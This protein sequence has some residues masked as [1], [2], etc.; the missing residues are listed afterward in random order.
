MN[1]ENEE[2]Y[3]QFEPK[4]EL[5]NLNANGIEPECI[6]GNC[7]VSCSGKYLEPCTVSCGGLYSS[8]SQNQVYS[9]LCNWFSGSTIGEKDKK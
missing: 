6:C 9:G 1:T 2:K 7:T 8:L 4:Y 3:M 5:N